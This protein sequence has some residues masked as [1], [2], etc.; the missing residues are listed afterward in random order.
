MFAAGGNA[1]SGLALGSP[2][3]CAPSGID[4]C[5][6]G[7]LHGLLC[8]VPFKRHNGIVAGDISF[9]DQVRVVENDQTPGGWA[10]LL[11]DCYGITTPSVTGVAV[12]GCSDGDVAFNIHFD[13]RVNQWPT[14]GFI[15][16]SSSTSITLKVQRP[17][18]GTRSW[19]ETPPGSGTGLRASRDSTRTPFK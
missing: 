2:I 10:G 5:V 3:N 18:L 4:R 6:G 9:G 16:T 13:G 19:S 15:P 8:A 1:V 11:G 14:F 7:A 17:P 12:I